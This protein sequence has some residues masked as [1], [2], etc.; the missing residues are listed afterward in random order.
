MKPKLRLLWT[1]LV[2]AQMGSAQISKS[3]LPVLDWNARGATPRAEIPFKLYRGYLIVVQGSLGALEG[4]NFLIDTGVNPTAVDSKIANKLRLTGP[5]HKLAL[6][7]QNTDVGQVVLPSLQIGPIRAESL[8][9]MIQD[10]SPL[11]E[12]V[13]ARIDAQVGFGVLSRSSFSID[14]RLKKIVFGLIESSPFSVPFDTGP[15]VITVQLWVHDEPIRVLVDTGSAELVVFECQLH[16]HLRQLP[17]TGGVRRFL[18]GAGKR[19]GLTEIWLPGVRLAATNIGLQKGFSADG[20]TNCGRSFDGVFGI[21]R[22]GLKWVAF[23]FEQRRF[24]WKR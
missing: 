3:V 14:Y 10:L 4:L 22:L 1:A 13:G 23:D 12:A 5:T 7:N 11:E 24:S 8:P 15:P 9:G 6:F 16:G 2:L 17:V 20:D 21:T 18:N 19:S